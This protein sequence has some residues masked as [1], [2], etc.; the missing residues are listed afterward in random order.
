MIQNILS[1][2][3]TLKPCSMI[4]SDLVTLV[5]SLGTFPYEVFIVAIHICRVPETP[6]RLK[7]RDEVLSSAF[8]L[9]RPYHTLYRPNKPNPRAGT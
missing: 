7:S 2:W 1:A 8:R 9:T 5:P 6:S 3:A 4:I